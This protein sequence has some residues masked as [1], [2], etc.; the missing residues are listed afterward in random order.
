MSNFV[1]AQH[2]LSWEFFHPKKQVWQSFGTSG[3]IQEKLIE[4]SELPNPFYGCN[5]E[6]FGWIENESWQLKSMFYL[7]EKEYNSKSLKIHKIIKI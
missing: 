4:S 3:S 1:F 5:E 6:Q 7:T 2:E